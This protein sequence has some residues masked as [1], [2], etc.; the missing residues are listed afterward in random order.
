MNSDY[1]NHRVEDPTKISSRQEKQIKKYVHDYFEKA[2]TKKK[3]HDKK[4]AE[5]KAREA[6]SGVPEA[7]AP[8]PDVKKEDDSD[9][10]Q[11]MAISDDEEEK[12]KQESAT[13]VTPMD[14]LLIA[15][16]LKRKRETED[17]LN[18]IR[19][20]DEEATPHKRLKSESPPRPPPPPP[21]TE[22]HED[23][24][25]RAEGESNS[26]GNPQMLAESHYSLVDHEALMDDSLYHAN[27]P[28]P[29][30]PPPHSRNPADAAGN[31]FGIRDGDGS[32]T[33]SIQAPNR[34]E[35]SDLE[36]EHDEEMV[37]ER[38]KQFPEHG[39]RPELAVQ[40]GA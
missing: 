21:V 8:T 29:P 23:V 27:R 6:E 11:D 1:K 18:E 10:A 37:D 19:K 34:S 40:S 33:E 9:D 31:D 5:R 3:E 36:M 32:N 26:E 20:E 22:I 30:P 4:K 14:Q 28:P 16:G 35:A 13:P 12:P 24:L 15:E 17:D 38:E 39:H 7:A 25:G 2:V